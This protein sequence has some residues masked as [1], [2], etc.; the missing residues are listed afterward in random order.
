MLI[1]VNQKSKSKSKS[2]SKNLML[3]QRIT[4]NSFIIYL[5]S[6]L[7]YFLI[8]S[9]LSARSV[10]VAPNGS[11]N[12]SIPIKTLP[13]VNGIQPNLSINYNSSAPNGIL[14]VGFQLGGLPAITRVN[15]GNGINYNAGDTFSGPG[16]KLILVDA[17]NRIY[18]SEN[19]DWIEYVPYTNDTTKWLGT[20]G[21]GNGPCFW[22]AY[23]TDG[24]IL[25]FGKDDGRVFKVG[26]YSVRVWAVSKVQDVYEN[27]YNIKYEIDDTNGDYYP[28]EIIQPLKAADS[29]NGETYKVTFSRQ[30]RNDVTESYAQ[31][32]KV[33]QDERIRSIEVKIADS[34]VRKYEIDYEL[35]APTGRSRIR[36]I[37]ECGSDG[38]TCFK[39]TFDWESETRFTPFLYLLLT[40]FYS[41]SYI[42]NRIKGAIN[43]TNAHNLF[44]HKISNGHDMDDADNWPTITNPDING[45]GHSDVC[46]RHDEGY[47]CSIS[48]GNGGFEHPRKALSDFS[49]DNDFDDGDD[50]WPTIRNPDINADGRSDVCARYDS[51]YT[52]YLSNGNG[53][54]IGTGG[55]L[56]DF[57]NGNDFDEGDDNWPTIGNPDINGD[58]RPD[59][60]GRHDS[61]YTCYLSDGNGTFRHRGEV[62]THMS[63]D[64]GFYGAD[65]WPTIKNPDINGD[66]RSDVCWR[67]D[68]GYYC[69]MSEGASNTFTNHQKKF[70]QLSNH[71]GFD[72][73]DDNW[74]TISHPDINGDGMSDTC[75]RAD[76]GY[77]CAMS[78][79]DGNFTSPRY[80]FGDY[81]RN[82]S[83]FDRDNWSTIRNPDINGDGMSDVCWRHDDGYYCAVS[84]GDGSFQDL[85][86]MFGYVNNHEDFDGD[87][88][89]TI[90]NPDIN[91]DG[92]SDVC[93]R[94]DHGYFCTMSQ[95]KPDH[96]IRIQHS[97]GSETTISYKPATQTDGA[98]GDNNGLCLDGSSKGYGRAC[99]I[100]NKSPRYLVQS[101]SVRE[102]VSSQPIITRYS[103]SDGR[104]YLGTVDQRADLGFA[105]MTI[106]RPDDTKVENEYYQQKRFRGILKKST[107]K[108]GNQIISTTENQDLKQW[109]L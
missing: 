51:G 66:G 23:T 71:A 44:T 64:E 46:W 80:V 33:R 87:N 60:C 30:P 85:G 34:L 50:N 69:A 92:R 89:Y 45:D 95:A 10:Q 68:D 37:Q 49:N 70:H 19:E 59:V 72:D 82:H 102:S 81:I 52:C 98:I 24:K 16:G 101:V 14:G 11:A 36:S 106:H 107:V 48:N 79:G 41:S 105:K 2:K 8:Y 18:H 4:K 93:W 96:I 65:N 21:C 90:T 109:G 32:A 88:K 53:I 61:G 40:S 76:D 99:G 62:L 55:N 20:G 43:F 103:Y 94:H 13:G 17:A 5:A 54:F 3:N 91:G 104:V 39:Q 31:S 42:I 15:N 108:L 83:G 38:T 7:L 35:S 25:E 77:Y 73:G 29:G 27:H 56:P 28:K 9:S 63:N 100:P 74:P 12:Y 78:K 75:W 26:T 6:L 67:H 86:K 57:G 97:L 84:K 1:N 47:Y 22:K 58:G